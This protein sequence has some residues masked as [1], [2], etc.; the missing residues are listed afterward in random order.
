MNP[1][2]FGAQ[3]PRQRI[4]GSPLGTRAGSKYV[5]GNPAWMLNGLASAGLLPDVDTKKKPATD[6]SKLLTTVQDTIT[7]TCMPPQASLGTPPTRV[8]LLESLA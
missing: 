7:R 3:V 4:K 5:G 6:T 2:F 1:P 8:A